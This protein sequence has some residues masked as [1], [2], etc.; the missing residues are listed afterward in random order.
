MARSGL[1][2]LLGNTPQGAR[3][4]RD[5]QSLYR[6]DTVQVVGGP[7]DGDLA[8]FYSWAT[9]H[10]Y[11]PGAAWVA[12]PGRLDLYN[13]PR[14]VFIKARALDD[15]KTPPRPNSP[16]RSG[17]Q[18]SE[19]ES[20]VHTAPEGNERRLDATRDFW[21]IRENGR[22]GSHSSHDDHSDESEP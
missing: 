9:R 14:V 21:Q 7:W 1:R 10:G 2:N 17:P 19:G 8:L 18:R 12:L 6:G 22:F 4:H 3:A 11:G 13:V 16:R 5:D 15:R 20:D